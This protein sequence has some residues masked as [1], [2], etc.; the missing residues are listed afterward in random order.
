MPDSPAHVV[1]TTFTAG[2]RDRVFVNVEGVTETA[3]LMV[4]LL[5]DFDRPVPEF[6]GEK[7]GLATANGVRAQVRFPSGAIPVGRPLALKVALPDSGEGRV[8]AVYV[9]D[10]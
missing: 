3:P 4:E 8:Y 2:E 6:S 5:D 1:T 10:E 7:A 9:S